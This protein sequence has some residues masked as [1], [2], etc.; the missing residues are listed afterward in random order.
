MPIAAPAEC[1]SNCLCDKLRL[2]TGGDGRPQ[3]KRRPVQPTARCF[4][5]VTK[6]GFDLLGAELANIDAENG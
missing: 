5:A 1:F 4:L 3:G 6:T 2:G